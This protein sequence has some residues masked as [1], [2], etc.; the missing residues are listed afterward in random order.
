MMPHTVPYRFVDGPS[1]SAVGVVAV[2]AA[3]PAAV[4]PVAVGSSTAG[5]C[6]AIVADRNQP[7]CNWVAGCDRMG[8]PSR[9]PDPTGTTA[10]DTLQL[11]RACPCYPAA[12]SFVA[13]SFAAAAVGSSASRVALHRAV[14]AD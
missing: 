3:G 2:A 8:S 4:A 13:C 6:A 9:D 14:V 5:C 10:A 12:D 7:S 11:D 1:S